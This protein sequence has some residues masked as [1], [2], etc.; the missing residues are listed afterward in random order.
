MARTAKRYM[1]STS[2]EINYIGYNVYNAGIYTRLSHERTEM[3]RSLSNSINAQIY[4]CTNYADEENINIYKTYIDYEYSGTNFERPSYKEMLQDIKNGIINCI[5]IKDLSRLGRE[6]LEM[7][8]LIEKV[9]P[10]LGVRFISIDDDLDTNKNLDNNKL[11]EINIKNIIN[12]MY[13]KD[14]S[15]KIKS[16]KRNKAEN[17]YFIGTVPPYGYKVIKTKKGQKLEVDFNV[18][19]IVQD[20]FRLYL[21]GVCSHTIAKIMNEKRYSTPRQYYR[22]KDIYTKNDEYQWSKS[23]INRILKNP[24]YTGDLIQCKT[25]N[26]LSNNI[27]QVFVDDSK[28]VIFKNAHEPLVDK[29]DYE[30]V[31]LELKN[32]KENS[33]FVLGK[34]QNSISFPNKY[35]DLIYSKENNK[36]LWRRAIPTSIYTDAKKYVFTSKF[37]DGRIYNFLIS[38]TEDE[39]DNIIVETLK[40]IFSNIL[41]KKN[42]LSKIKNIINLQRQ[43]IDNELIKLN[44]QLEK[45]NL[46]IKYNYERYKLG[47][48]NREIY[49]NN[50]KFILNRIKNLE[51]KVASS[52]YIKKTFLNK[53]RYILDLASNILKFSQNFAIDKELLNLLIEKIIVDSNKNIKIILKF[54]I[55]KPIEDWFDDV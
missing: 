23:A 3:W 5:I 55:N 2:N 45:E 47:S 44:E 54:N 20:I 26:D 38:I 12:D 1:K 51:E 36:P 50:R 15:V 34:K 35:K 8:I 52:K 40:I 31:Q 25:E 32:R 18:K 9:F 6:Y 4:Y 24:L 11:F 33:D 13:A 41:D 29:K 7:G 30:K 46:N 28:W 37:Y 19:F 22:T 53:K 48:L 10:F 43:K 42:F 27:K 14:I 21:E 16:S 49:C 17:G 39:L